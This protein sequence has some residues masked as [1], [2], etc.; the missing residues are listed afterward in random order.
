MT[1]IG[2]W[3]AVTGALRGGRN[4][5]EIL[6][7]TGRCDLRARQVEQLAQARGIPIRVAARAELD[8]LLA[9]VNHQG[10][11]ARMAAAAVAGE[12]ELEDLLESLAA[13]LLLVLDGV[14]DPHNLGACLRSAAAAGADAVIVPRDRAAGLTPAARKVAAGGAELVPLVRVT[15]LAR[16]LRGL[17]AAGLRVVGSAA[18]ADQSIHEAVLTGPV[19]LV[20]GGE[21][22]GLRRLTRENCDL[23][24]GIPMAAGLASLNVSVAA[25]VCL[26]EAVRQRGE[27]RD[28]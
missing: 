6:L 3:H 22:S 9:G 1:T 26:F 2:G 21:G 27:E 5:E 28:W 17:R 19:A 14:Q 11:A 24:V 16:C 7:L 20:L 23:M 12:A 18:D 13:P 8:R 4:I 10:C 15:N 25:G